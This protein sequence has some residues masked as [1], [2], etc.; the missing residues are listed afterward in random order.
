MTLPG[1]V[2]VKEEVRTLLDARPDDVTF[3]DV[4][5]A[6]LLRLKVARAFEDV[7][8]GRTYSQEEID[9]E[10]HEPGGIVRI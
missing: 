4:M 8:A 1:P 3:E 6:L 10:W 7:R 9:A 2:N 5:D